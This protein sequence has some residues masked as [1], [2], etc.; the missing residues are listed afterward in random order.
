VPR[1]S[2]K[3][4]K[5]LR[6]R[7]A[8]AA[9]RGLPTPEIESRG[10][11]SSRFSNG[12][13][14]TAFEPTTAD[15][16]GASLAT[17]KGWFATWPLSVKILGFAILAMLGFGLWRTLTTSREPGLD[18]PTDLTPPPKSDNGAVAPG[19]ASPR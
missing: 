5:N 6:Q 10:S 14:S 11:P 3:D 13:D 15:L 16:V 7:A 4:R 19:P 2:R 9:D 17:K 12:P 1:A 8:N 18:T